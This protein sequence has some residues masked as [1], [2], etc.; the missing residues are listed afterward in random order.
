MFERWHN[1]GFR[2]LVPIIPPGAA[3]A[4]R[5]RI[6]DKDRGKARHGCSLR[7]INPA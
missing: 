6:P 3:I 4:P 5:S 1:A 7:S 2:D